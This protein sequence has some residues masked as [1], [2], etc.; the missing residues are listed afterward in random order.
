VPH[1]RAALAADLRRLGLKS[2][3]LVMVHASVR[4]VG[5]AFGGPD[6][7]HLAIEDAV[8]PG[9]TLMMLLGCPD[10]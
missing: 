4:A 6:V 1:S 5:S 9:G 10:G 2:G 8:A 3:D 7:I